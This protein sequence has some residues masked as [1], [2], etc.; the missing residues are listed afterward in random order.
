MVQALHSEDFVMGV[1][2]VD[3]IKNVIRADAHFYLLRSLSIF[4]LL[5]LCGDRGRNTRSP[6]IRD[7]QY[8]RFVT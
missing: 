8:G 6:G 7:K 5:T 2:S 3:I 4:R 1:V